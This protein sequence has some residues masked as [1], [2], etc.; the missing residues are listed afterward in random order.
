MLRHVSRPFSGLFSARGPRH[1]RRGLSLHRRRL[2]AVEGLEGRVLLAATVYTV[3]ATTDTGAGSGTTGDLLYC[4]DQ[5]NANPKTAGSLIQFDPTVFGMPQ[6]IILSST[7]TLSETAGPEVIDGPGANLV[8]VSGNNRNEVYSVSDGVTATITGQTISH[9]SATDYAGGIEN[10]GTLT[11]SGSA[12]SDDSS[13]YDS[14]GI[15]NGGTLT[16]SNSTISDNHSWSE[17]G[18][19]TNYGTVTVSNSTISDNS[20]YFGGGITTYGTMTLS[21]S[22]ISDNSATFDG[23]GIKNYNSGTLTVS[24]STISDNSATGDGGGIF[25]ESYGTLTI[26]NSTISD[27]SAT[28]DGGGIENES[29]LTVANS[30]IAYNTVSS[31]GF[32]GG[33]DADASTATLNN[34]IVALNT[35]GTGSGAT[36]DDIAQQYAGVVSPS[37]AYNLVGTGGSGGLT[38]GVDGN[39]VGVAS[40]EIGALAENGGPTQTIALLPGSPAIDAGSNALAV[41]PS[42]GQ[43][44]TT[45][46]R[47]T[48][49]ARIFNG[50]VDI[51]AYEVQP[52]LVVTTQPPANV[53][54]GTAFGLTVT[55]EDRSGAVDASFSGTV[56]LTLAT[57]PSGATLG[58]TLSVPVRSG[59]AAFTGLTLD[60]VG[61]GYTLQVSSSGLTSLTTSAFNVTPAAAS[62]LVLTQSPATAAVGAEF[63]LVVAAEDQFGNLATTFGGSVAVA[64]LNNPSGTTLGGTRTV[65]A[66]GGV[67]T[68]AGLTLSTVGTGY[69]LQVSSNGLTAA[70]TQPFNVTAVGNIYTVNSLGDTGTGSGLSGDLRYVITQA[71]RNAGSTVVFGVTGTITL[72]SALPDLITDVTINGPGA[73]K[74]TVA[75]SSAAGTPDFRIF[76]IDTKTEVKI[77]G[78]TITGGGASQG[79]GLL[80]NGGTVSLTNVTVIDNQAVGA[81]GVAGSF[82]QSGPGTAGGDGSSGQGGGLYL[83][84]GSLTLNDD[85]I[86]S[87]VVR[88]GA[89]GAGGAGGS[90][91]SGGAG[92]AGGLAAGGGIYAA[93]GTLVLNN[94]VIQSNQAIGG[95]G[96]KAGAGGSGVPG[97]AGS[98]GTNYLTGTRHDGGAGGA[99]GGGGEGGHGGAGGAAKGGGLYLS[100]GSVTIDNSSIQADRA[101]GG[102][103]GVGGLGGA[104]GDGGDGGNGGTDR[105]G[106]AAYGGAGGAGGGGAKGGNGGAGGAAEGGG[107]YL[108]AG[109]VTIDNSSIQADRASGG[110]G[111][112]G[113]LGGAG[114]DG[115]DG[116]TGRRGMAFGSGS[117]RNGGDGGDGGDGGSG[118]EGALGGAGGGGA[119]GGLYVVGG[120]ISL[121]SSTLESDSALGGQGG[122]GSPGGRGGRGGDGGFG[123]TGG[124]G[125][126]PRLGRSPTGGIGGSGGRGGRAGNGALGG[127]GGDGGGAYGGALY[128]AQGTVGLSF[129]TLT[130][131]FASGGHGGIGGLGGFGGSGGQ[132]ASGGLGGYGGVSSFGYSGIT[133]FPGENG[134]PGGSGG[135]GG[136]GGRAGNGALGGEGGAGGGAYGG[137]LY[138]AEG[139]VGLSFDTLNANLASGGPGG[140]GGLGGT[141]NNGGQGGDGER[142]GSGAAGGVGFTGPTTLN[143][144]HIRPGSGGGGGNGGRGGS[145]GSG[146]HGATGGA[147]GDGGAAQGGGLYVSDGSIT[148]TDDTLSGNSALAGAGALGGV[149]GIGGNGGEGGGGGSA[150]PGGRGG[151]FYKD[152]IILYYAPSGPPG[153][154]GV[155]GNGGVGGDGG[156]GGP[157]GDGGSGRGGGLFV[158]DG[159]L[160]MINDT[161]ADNTAQGAPGGAGGS[162]GVGGTSGASGSAAIAGSTGGAQGGGLYAGGGMVSV[163]NSTLAYNDVAS[164]GAGGGLDVNAGTATL[165]NTIVALNTNGIGSGAP[166]DD[167]AGAVASASAYNLIG[168][169]GSGGLVNG[170]DGNQVGVANPGLGPLAY[171]GGPTQTIDL[172]PGS[173]A[174]DAGS[175]ALAV[176]PTTG[177]PLATDQRGPGFVRIDHGT[178]DIGAYES[179]PAASNAVSVEW[180]TQSVALQTAADGLRLLPVGR[181]TDLPWLGIDQLQITLVQAQPLTAAEV[182]VDSAIGINY[183]P[184]T[185][186]GSGTSYTLDLAHPINAADLVTITIVNPGISLFNRRIDVLPG[187]FNDDGVVNS[188]DLVGVRNEWLRVGGAVPT[189]FGDINGDG[190]VNLTD[191]NDVRARIGTALPT[192]SAASVVGGAVV[193]GGPTVVRISTAGST[194]TGGPVARVAVSRVRPRAEILLVTRGRARSLRSYAKPKSVHH[195]PT[196]RERPKGERMH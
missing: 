119:G 161:V 69:T 107:L 85:L 36:P 147:G 190:V 95:A 16:I 102:S 2:W 33:L 137:A 191:Y 192:V 185:V 30:T 129:D 58:G 66:Q 171:Y 61:T 84:G 174:I 155:G 92:G 120:N 27:N 52:Y 179:L 89:G 158:G 99:G 177:Q 140:I 94:D 57:N 80:D 18:G 43:P 78:L 168:T 28:G 1:S 144:L 11:V 164:G 20:G 126:P 83:A 96:G 154:P 159:S 189:I 25:N 130:A 50:T 195:G 100:A 3:N 37:S 169:G 146:G 97:N 68:F 81:D 145:G 165:D 23:G 141:G 75:R 49:F 45:D 178:V 194:Q 51:G 26:S 87:N 186:S 70:T 193:G 136:R 63:A 8:T 77:V 123:G 149:G 167:I 71:D 150:G 182:F 133:I 180:G 184:V 111:G 17:D 176:D 19:I 60:N 48:G 42:T 110:S 181:N 53:T 88:G 124:I 114:G 148:L 72:A 67:A 9:G 90:G 118:G 98:P 139:T 170:V 175:N 187:D 125:R 115:G 41:D 93:D 151:A 108:S 22:A 5:A 127:E 86:A 4:I 29:T 143:P 15:H 138:V 113:G 82:G 153:S 162:G 172:L 64:L 35:S 13:V 10:E 38:N 56:T 54:A 112:V 32:G 47:G 12:I 134:G 188:Q 105:I 65:T 76:T 116:G 24:N 160:T 121:S 104:G 44:L 7:L 79:G 6:A 34:T 73:T 59:V 55:V 103:G 74:L 196:E 122:P 183:G 62:Q 21:G 163:V 39:Q 46:Q 166:A 101:S 173:P 131:D 31:G 135:L 40:P 152:G 157:G 117:N 128:V 91:R 132:G 156:N 14:G 106:D 142:G 109:N